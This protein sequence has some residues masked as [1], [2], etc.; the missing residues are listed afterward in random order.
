MIIA[1]DFSS[2]QKRTWRVLGHEFHRERLVYGSLVTLVVS[3]KLFGI[4]IHLSRQKDT[5]PITP[6]LL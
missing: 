5:S 1:D 4:S 2:Y 3:T 6:P